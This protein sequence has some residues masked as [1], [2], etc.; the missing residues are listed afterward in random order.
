MTKKTN[1]SSAVVHKSRRKFMLST[2]G[3]AAVTILS[4]GP[5]SQNVIAQITN[6][7]KPLKIGVI[8]AGW[9]GGTVGRTWVKAG[10]EVLFSSRH[11]AELVTMTN[12]L[13]S[14]ATAGTPLEA[15]KFGT[16]LL[17]AVPYE[18]IPQLGQDLKDHIKGKIVLD[19]CNPSGYSNSEL[20][21]EAAKK[22]VF[23]ILC[24]AH[25][26]RCFSSRSGKWIVS[27][28]SVKF[29]FWIGCVQRSDALSM[30]A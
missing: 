16:I 24:Q 1:P 19:A 9:L 20:A 23:R 4:A 5:F 28:A 14:R 30:P 8:G 6:S 26:L 22:R 15:A 13:G 18:A 12:E 27:W 10:H 17:F 11:P 29:Q 25:R 3:A 7:S 21:R 2:L